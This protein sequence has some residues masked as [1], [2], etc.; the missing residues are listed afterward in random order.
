MNLE[1]L[2]REIAMCK[3]PN[4]DAW[5]VPIPDLEGMISMI[6]RQESELAKSHDENKTL[7]AALKQEQADVGR[8]TLELAARQPLADSLVAPGMTVDTP[9]FQARMGDMLTAQED[10]IAQGISYPYEKARA[11]LLGHIDQHTARAV[12]AAVALER[13]K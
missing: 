11:K 4:V 6:Q 8:L 5:L 2:A 13:G 3:S 10:S 12:A 9:E 7:K 1:K